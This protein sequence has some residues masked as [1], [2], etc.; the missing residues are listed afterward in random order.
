VLF[1]SG[2]VG[3]TSMPSHGPLTVPLSCAVP[4]STRR[5]HSL[6]FQIRSSSPVPL[7]APIDRHYAMLSLRLPTQDCHTPLYAWLPCGLRHYISGSYAMIT[8]IS[9]VLVRRYLLLTR[10]TSP[11]V[12]SLPKLQSR[13]TCL[14]IANHIRLSPMSTLR[15]NDLR[16]ITSDYV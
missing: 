12:F 10:A 9:F 2:P 15:E 14:A 8:T 4:D 5:H 3:F 7:A 13:V 6:G 11:N 16:A 1:F